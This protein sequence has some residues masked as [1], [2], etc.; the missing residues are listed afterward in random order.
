MNEKKLYLYADMDEQ[1]KR[2]NRIVVMIDSLFYLFVSLLVL[3]SA[4]GGV[5]TVGY[6]TAL[7]TIIS[8]VIMS[9]IMLFVKNKKDHRI[10]YIANIGLLIVTFLVGF[11]YDNS[12]LRFMA[13]IPLI[14]NIVYFDKRFS[15][16]FG[17]LTA[18]INVFMTIIKV[19]VLHVYKGQA[20]IE[21]YGATLAICML[22]I[23]IYNTVKVLKRFNEDTMGNLK[24]EQNNQK[25]ML[26]DVLHISETIK[27]KIAEAMENMNTLYKST[28]VVNG[29]VKDISESTQST[30]QNIQTQTIMTG[31]IQ[32]SIEQTIT[33]SG[34]ILKD[35]NQS[36]ELN[37]KNKE[38]M[39]TLKEHS[40]TISSNNLKVSKSMDKLQ[41]SMGAVKNIINTIFEISNQTNLLALNASIESARAGEAGR[42]FA[43]VAEEIRKLAEKTKDE[44]DSIETILSELMEEASQVGVQV[45][46][47]LLA[48]QKQEDLISS[49][50]EGFDHMSLNVSRL[51]QNVEIIDKM[52]N[53]L[54]DSN[55]QIVENIMQLSAT[56]EEIS[57]TSLQS[58]EISVKNLDNAET[59]KFI[60]D[61]ILNESYKLDKYYK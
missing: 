58:E 48:T 42:G 50:S 12:Y 16:I 9:T 38:L 17:I 46:N 53:E 18:V 54:S 10:K 1:V 29:S 60:L 45:S 26:E 34:N 37:I 20:I 19:S 23:V 43:V 24:Q 3:L 56:T 8:I 41:E 39:N 31:N 40:A 2:A 28:E 35:A 27:N 30:A 14:A 7:L 25:I 33:T 11:A 47:S 22:T 36:E 44:T 21:Q 49:T 61:G 59:T 55:H 6:T 32:K 52:L 15:A 5:R 51:N 57:A 13:A 4:I